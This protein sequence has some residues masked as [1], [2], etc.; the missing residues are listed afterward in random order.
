MFR[1]AAYLMASAMAQTLNLSSGP[2]FVVSVPSPLMVVYGALYVAAAL[3][4]AV[5]VFGKRD[6]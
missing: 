4:V 3:F 2:M 6:L 1:R 5:R